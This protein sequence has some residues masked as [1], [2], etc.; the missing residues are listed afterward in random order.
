MNAA[1]I[2][3]VSAG[4][5]PFDNTGHPQTGNGRATLIGGFLLV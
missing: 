4:G 3:A 1:A 2:T 5:V